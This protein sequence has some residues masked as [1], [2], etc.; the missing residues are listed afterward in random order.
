MARR[1]TGK[2]APAKKDKKAK[3][4]TRPLWTGSIQFG[5]VN[6]PVR[7]H[8]AQ[9]SSR[10]DFDLLDKRDFARVRYRRVNEK[11]GKEVDWNQ[12]VKGYAYDKGEYVALSDQDFARASAEASQTI[13]ISEF[14]DGAEISPVY[15]DTPYYLEPAKNSRR[16]YAL[17]RE[18]MKESGRIGIAGIVLRTRGHLAAVIADGPLLILNTLRY[19][20]ELRD[21]SRFDSAPANDKKNAPSPQEVKMAEQLIDSM[22]GR[23]QPA[24][25]KDDYQVHLLKLIE[26]KIKTGKTKAVDSAAE[27]PRAKREGKVID[28][29]H[30]LRQSVRQAQSKEGAAARK[31]KAG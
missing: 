27:A 6:I 31:R 24:K 4:R 3:S 1:K 16:A 9:S 30:L 8:S 20:H 18:V 12:I 14:I 21:A 15:Y 26:R 10:P 23:W 28:I 19:A 13:Q 29:M 25:Y 22:A 5:L 7:L 2:R 17:L 11:T